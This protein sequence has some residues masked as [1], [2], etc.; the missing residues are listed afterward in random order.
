MAFARYALF[1]AVYWH[2]AVRAMKAML[3]RAIWKAIPA[4]QGK[5]D[6][7][8]RRYGHFYRQF[9]S[10]ALSELAVPA[11]LSLWDASSS[12][13]LNSADLDQTAGTTTV[14]AWH[15]DLSVADLPSGDLRM[16]RWL[17]TCTT[18]QGKALLQML[19]GRNLFKRLLVVSSH[20][21]DQLWPAL[22][23]FAERASAPEKIDF[24]QEVQTQLI[25]LILNL[26]KRPS[27][28]NGRTISAL[29]PEAIDFCEA[30]A[31][32]GDILFLVDIPTD[33]PASQVDLCYVPEH[34]LGQPF[35]A[36]SERVRLSY[37]T[38][39]GNL[40]ESFLES[41]GKVRVF[42]HPDIVNTAE[43]GLSREDIEGV[44]SAAVRQVA[45][46]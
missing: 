8:S 4:T 12:P 30:M 15:P 6:K 42:V 41:V 2:H 1:G 18:L 27:E 21:A 35:V 17:H 32:R 3:H 13:S 31:T 24:Q 19:C 40:A 16:I 36:T 33:R 26:G 37:S 23:R 43:A 38:V 7:R 44:L 34:R 22:V 28:R 14:T 20:R 11:Q 46:R 29:K 45:R 10:T 9:I 25:D 5:I 39:W